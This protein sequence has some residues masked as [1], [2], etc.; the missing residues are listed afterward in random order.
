M[1]KTSSRDQTD[2]IDRP[3]V[4][5]PED[6]AKEESAKDMTALPK[7]EEVPK[8]SNNSSIDPLNED[9]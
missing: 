9:E 1:K 8:M 4:E 5:L 7:I 6:Q 3:T 2:E